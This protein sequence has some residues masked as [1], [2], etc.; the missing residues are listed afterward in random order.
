MP[1]RGIWLSDGVVWLQKYL[2]LDEQ[3]GLAARCREFIDGPA[4]GYVPTVRGGGKMRVRMVC[5]GRHWKP[6]AYRHEAT[7]AD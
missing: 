7:R 5:L 4:G 2:P 3:Q 6:L 1:E